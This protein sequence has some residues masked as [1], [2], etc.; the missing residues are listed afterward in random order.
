M[1]LL[2]LFDCL[3]MMVAV[4]DA[5]CVVIGGAVVGWLCVCWSIVCVM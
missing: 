2:F 4:V 1:V 3:S 5:I